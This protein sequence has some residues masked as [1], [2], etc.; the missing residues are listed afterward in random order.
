MGA[1]SA[2]GVFDFWVD[3]PLDIAG[4]SAGVGD[5]LEDGGLEVVFYPVPGEFVPRSKLD[6]AV[7]IAASI[8]ANMAATGVS[9]SRLA[10]EWAAAGQCT[11]LA[12]ILYASE[13]CVEGPVRSFADFCD[14]GVPHWV[15]DAIWHGVSYCFWFGLMVCRVLAS[16]FPQFRFGKMGF[17]GQNAVSLW[18]SCAFPASTIRWDRCYPMWDM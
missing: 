14:C 12:V 3:G 15:V 16:G 17:C 18:V 7:G 4:E 6:F 9:V 8:A 1:W 10:V 2:D 13:P 11:E 5:F